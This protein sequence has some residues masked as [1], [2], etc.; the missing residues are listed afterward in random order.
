VTEPTFFSGSSVSECVFGPSLGLRYRDGDNIQHA[1]TWTA[2]LLELDQP[3]NSFGV[4]LGL[5]TAR[6]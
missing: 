3:P 4:W 2:W 5:A 1:R 6:N